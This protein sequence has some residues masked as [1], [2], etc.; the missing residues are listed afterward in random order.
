MTIEALSQVLLSGL[1][2]GGI[3]A[4]MA[5]SFYVILNSTEILNFAQGEWM[6]LS[7][8]FGVVLLQVG[9][10]YVLAVILAIMGATAAALI[11]ERAVIRPLE[12]RNASLAVLILS[13]LGIMIVVRYATGLLLGRHDA[14]LPGLLPAGVIRLSENVFLLSNWL[15]VYAVTAAVFAGVWL[16]LNHTWLGRSLRVAAIDPTGA[17]L[18]GI[19]LRRVRLVA[20][21]LGG[22]IAALVAWLYAPL[23]AAG[24]L[25]GAIPGIKGFIAL[26]IGG[27][28]TPFGS[29]IGGLALGVTEVAAAR[30][31]PSTYSEAAAFVILMV[32]LFLRPNGLL[33][34]RRPLRPAT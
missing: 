17:V 22:F 19:D 31:L 21:G 6:M 33:A 24:Y 10:P 29:L 5:L 18:C 16:F 3:Y 25:I 27:M 34:A 14:P 1:Q 30:F 13:L 26:L 23:Y 9:V 7:A 15:A 28:A 32:V 12:A 2:V 20:F 11:A 8:M 4:L